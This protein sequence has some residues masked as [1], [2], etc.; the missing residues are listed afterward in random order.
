MEEW[1]KHHKGKAVKEIKFNGY[2]VKYVKKEEHEDFQP[3]NDKT[4]INIDKEQLK[5]TKNGEKIKVRKKDKLAIIEAL[6]QDNVDKVDEILKAL[7]S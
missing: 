2:E 6:K 4:P 1:Y 7:K 5:I 3:K